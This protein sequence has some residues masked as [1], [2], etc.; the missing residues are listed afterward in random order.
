MVTAR[1]VMAAARAII[2]IQD[3]S[4][5]TEFGSDIEVNLGWA[6]LLLRC[7]KFVRRKATIANKK[8]TVE[9]FTPMNK[10]FLNSLVAIVEM[11][12]ILHSWF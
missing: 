3:R 5:L 4:K 8:L 7:M 2:L 12:E 9:S 1:V 11:E 10:D 6:Y